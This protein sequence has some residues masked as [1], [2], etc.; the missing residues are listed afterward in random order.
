[1]WNLIIFILI[2]LSISILGALVVGYYLNLAKLKSR[3]TRTLYNIYEELN[4][5]TDLMDKLLE[6]FEFKSEYENEMYQS[7]DMLSNAENLNEQAIANARMSNSLEVL[8]IRAKESN[9]DKKFLK[10]VDEL[11]KTEELLNHYDDSYNNTVYIYNHKLQVFPSKW[12]A[13]Y[14]GFKNAEYFLVEETN[15]GPDQDL[16][17]IHQEEHPTKQ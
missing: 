2:V 7:I 13:N 1:M 12:V 6:N 9:K 16:N 4:I 8:F 15:K 3:L 10:L 5:K 17:Q 14:F 11:K